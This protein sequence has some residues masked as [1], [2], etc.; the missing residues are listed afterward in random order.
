MGGFARNAIRSVV[1]YMQNTICIYP[2]ETLY[3]S[4]HFVYNSAHS[5]HIDA[6][7]SSVQSLIFLNIFNLQD[8]HYGHPPPC[9]ENYCLPF[10]TCN[11]HFLK[12]FGFVLTVLHSVHSAST[13]NL[14][15]GVEHKFFVTL[16]FIRYGRGWKPP[17]HHGTISPRCPHPGLAA[18]E[19]L[20]DGLLDLLQPQHL[21]GGQSTQ[22]PVLL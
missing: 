10:I 15:P 13:S 18:H 16:L 3:H 4:T 22:L 9:D 7:N 2:V 12:I 17:Q 6:R 11:Y 20:H 1:L 8:H 5:T 19:P 21:S 14:C